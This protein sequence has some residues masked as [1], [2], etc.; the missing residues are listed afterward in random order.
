[1]KKIIYGFVFLLASTFLLC[2]CGAAEFLAPGSEQMVASKND[3]NR[4]TVKTGAGVDYSSFINSPLLAGESG[5]L[6]VTL[7]TYADAGRLEV[8]VEAEAGLEL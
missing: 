8:W 7:N 1:M 4:A 5:Q 2:A 6:I 3:G